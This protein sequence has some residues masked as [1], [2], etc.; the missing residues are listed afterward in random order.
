MHLVILKVLLFMLSIPGGIPTL[1]VA[2][3]AGY[4]LRAGLLQHGPRPCLQVIS[5]SQSCF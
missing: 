2:C 5:H 4:P 1:E 3:Y